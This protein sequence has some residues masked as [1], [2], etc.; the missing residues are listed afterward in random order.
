MSIT[1]T[2]DDFTQILG[3]SASELAA[4]TE[5]RGF[6]TLNWVTTEALAARAAAE[7]AISAAI[8]EFGAEVELSNV[9]PFCGGWSFHVLPPAITP[10]HDCGEAVMA[11]IAALGFRPER[12]SVNGR[13][14]CGATFYMWP[15]A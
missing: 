5:R 13:E 8:A 12:H 3:R 4:A 6:S 2:Q 14:G 11:A 9:S 10:S 1:V 15:V 7:V